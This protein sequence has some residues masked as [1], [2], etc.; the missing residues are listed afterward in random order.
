[1]RCAAVLLLLRAADGAAAGAGAGAWHL[2]QIGARATPM[3]R[4]N[5]SRDSVCV[6]GRGGGVGSE[7]KRAKRRSRQT[8]PLPS[9]SSLHFT[10]LHSSLVFYLFV[11]VVF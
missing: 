1:M 9:A 7:C 4:T 11:V 6:W 8:L 2:T 3:R 10:A 5:R